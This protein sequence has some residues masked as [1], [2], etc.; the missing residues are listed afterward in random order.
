VR[1]SAKPPLPS[2]RQKALGK[3]SGTR[4]SPDFGSVVRSMDEIR[5][6]FRWPFFV[7]HTTILTNYLQVFFWSFDLFS[8]K[9]QTSHR[10]YQ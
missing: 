10:L 7:D 6:Y 2:A 1:L 3:E 9:E 8:E 4:Q 5:R